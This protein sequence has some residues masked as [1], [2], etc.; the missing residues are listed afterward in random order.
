[1]VEKLVNNWYDHFVKND[2]VNITENIINKLDLEYSI[3]NIY[4][5]KNKVFRVFQE[6]SPE[7]VKLIILGQD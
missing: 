6:T 4:P 2:L 5:Y 7:N 1:M 3:K